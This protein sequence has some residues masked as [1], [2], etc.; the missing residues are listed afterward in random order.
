M[1]LLKKNGVKFVAFDIESSN[2]LQYLQ[3][4]FDINM[5]G[6]AE[7]SLRENSV[8]VDIGANVGI[9][10]FYLAKK[11]P[12]AKVYAFEPHPQNFENLVRGI[13]ENGITNVFPFQLAVYDDSESEI[14][15][16]LDEE[17]SGA[18]SLFY[19]S[20]NFAI[21]ETISMKDLLEK[22]GH[23]KIDYLKI[24]CEGAEFEIFNSPVFYHGDYVFERTFVEIHKFRE[25][26]G[27]ASIPELFTRI[28]TMK[29]LRYFS[30]VL[31]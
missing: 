15:I 16:Y 31:I 13:E 7:F 25:S 3:D 26:E 23:N 11:Y 9:I 14:E 2:T 22:I 1:N 19:P 18:S 27:G 17:N 6:L 4:E 20:E 8:I 21:A 10:S 30:Y 5:M 29:N 24:D 28:S 12:S